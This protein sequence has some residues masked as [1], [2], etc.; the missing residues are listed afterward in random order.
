M[1]CIRYGDFNQVP[2]KGKYRDFST[3]ED[4]GRALYGIT[5]PA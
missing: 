5:D 1:V 3:G 2:E 4:K